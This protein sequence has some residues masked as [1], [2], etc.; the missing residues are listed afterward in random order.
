[1]IQPNKWRTLGQIRLIEED[2][3]FCVFPGL[4]GVHTLFGIPRWVFPREALEKDTRF[5]VRMIVP[6]ESD[7]RWTDF[8]FEDF[9]FK[10]NG[11]WKTF[12]VPPES[13]TDV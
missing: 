13:Q 1:M 5:Y 6:H 7:V 10:L 12:Q 2:E 9:E 4:M 11:E 8:E 3:I